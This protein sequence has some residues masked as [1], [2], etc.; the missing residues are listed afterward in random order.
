MPEKEN[1]MQEIF[2]DEV[3]SGMVSD[4]IIA[5]SQVNI[6]DVNRFGLTGLMIAA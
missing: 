3:N 2:F 6:N 1:E 4:S 5:S